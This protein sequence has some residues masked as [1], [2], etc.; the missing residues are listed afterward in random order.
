MDNQTLVEIYENISTLNSKNLV[1]FT[2]ALAT[3]VDVTTWVTF[4]S[5]SLVFVIL[6]FLVVKKSPK[7]MKVYKWYICCNTL[8]IYMFEM[9]VNEL[10]H[11]INLF[12]SSTPVVI[13]KS[14]R[15]VNKWVGNEAGLGLDLELGLC[16]GLGLS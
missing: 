9:L 6:I 14:T 8:P 4:G 13:S 5:S 2:P 3:V 7:E 12:S 16:L 11:P 10:V 15:I 1:Y